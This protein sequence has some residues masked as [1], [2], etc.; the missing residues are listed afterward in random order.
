MRRPGAGG[1]GR[2][3]A[4]LVPGEARRPPAPPLALVLVVFLLHG[5]TFPAAAARRCPQ[6]LDEQMAAGG[7]ESV[8]FQLQ[9]QPGEVRALLSATA[10]GLD[11]RLVAVRQRVHKH[12]GASSPRL[13]DDVWEA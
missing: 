1:G 7:S 11:A 5:R 13:V 12:L 3:C 6:K 8:H 9:F 10:A 4:G 2:F